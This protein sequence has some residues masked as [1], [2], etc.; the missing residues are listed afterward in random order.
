MKDAIIEFIK[1]Q[2]CASVCCV[3]ANGLPYCFSCYYVL[4]ADAMLL[5]FKSSAETKHSS[6][7]HQK[8]KVAGTILPDK[9]NM[10]Q[11]RGIQFDAMILSK[12]DVL[13]TDA[14]SKYHQHNPAAIAIAGDVYCIQLDHIKMT[15]STLGYGKK[16]NWQ[17]ADQPTA[18]HA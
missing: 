3:D 11:V 10:L 6:I 5:Y 4:N 16:F 7:L 14:F 12:E 13:A 18:L 17:R 2:S 9:L 1:K 8:P 15:D